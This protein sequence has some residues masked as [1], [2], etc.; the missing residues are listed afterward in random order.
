MSH[1]PPPRS[2]PPLYPLRRPPNTTP[3]PTHH[4]TPLTLRRHPHT[5]PSPSHHTAA[6]QALD[7]ISVFT[8]V[9]GHTQWAVA[10]LLDDQEW[11]SGFLQQNQKL[12]RE[13]YDVL[14]GGWAWA[15]RGWAGGL[16]WQA[17]SGR[18]SGAG[19]ARRGWVAAGLL[20]RKPA[21]LLLA[22]APACA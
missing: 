18:L 1:L 15:G 3:P 10:Q 5:T 19:A 12:L 8:G 20:Q 21:G 16:G 9:S 17:G 14:A 7:P 11:V 4:T 13:S 2:P 6:L 22:A